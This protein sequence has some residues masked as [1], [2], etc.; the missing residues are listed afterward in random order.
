MG[1]NRVFNLRCADKPTY[2]LWKLKIG[3]A[4]NTSAGKIKEIKLEQYLGN[5]SSQFE[6]WRYLRIPEEGFQ[7]EVETGDLIL[8]Q[9]KKRFKMNASSIDRIGLIV[10]LNID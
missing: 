9:T 5:I 8:C 7:K 2:D 10:K 1:S 4:I 3:H 6:F